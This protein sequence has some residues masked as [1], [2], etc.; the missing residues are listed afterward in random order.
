VCS[1]LGTG[2]EAH[3]RR[4]IKLAITVAIVSVLVFMF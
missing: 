1:M 4:T 3:M 2:M